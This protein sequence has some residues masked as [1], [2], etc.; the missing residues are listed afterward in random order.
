MSFS[1]LY[2]VDSSSPD[3][4]ALFGRVLEVGLFDHLFH[5][6]LP[7][8]WFSLELSALL[9][10]LII[11]Q[12]LSVHDNSSTFTFFFTTSYSLMTPITLTSCLSSRYIPL[13]AGDL[14]I[15]ISWL[16]S[17]QCAPNRSPQLHSR[18][19]PHLKF[20]IFVRPAGTSH[21]RWPF[22]PSPPFLLMLPKF[23]SSV[24]MPS[25]SNSLL[26]RFPIAL[27]LTHSIFHVFY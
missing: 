14:D 11:V 10:T 9:S 17:H 27:S 23:M 3:F 7:L 2:P 1:L 4:Q 15:D 16:L 19:M 24:F 12:T 25:C 18:L 26:I 5:H 13:S 22:L 20:W 21:L 6:P 8:K